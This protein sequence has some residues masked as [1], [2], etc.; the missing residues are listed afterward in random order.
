[1]TDRYIRAVAMDW[2]RIAPDSF[3]RN[4]PA[5]KDL[6]YL[7]FHRN[8]TFFAGENGSGKS[9]LLEAIALAYG[10]NA[11]GGTL[12]YR[13]STYNE[14]GV[15]A[16]AVRLIRGVTGKPGAG[17]FF[18]AESFFNVATAIMEKYNDDGRLPDYHQVSHGESFLDFMSGFDRQGIYL[19]D[20][21]E[22]ALSPQRQLS[23]LIHMIRMAE[24][25]SQFIVATHSPIL[26]GIPDAEI[27]DF[28]EDGIRPCDYEDTESYRVTRL[29]L[30]N[31]E[32]MLHRLLDDSD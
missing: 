8:I 28:R 24:T 20:E 16:D 7:E 27:L 5:M 18:R 12:N 26:L 2:N 4:I 10:F 13:F 32:L 3:L 31:R 22:A 29:F 23:L 17:Y 30:E 14:Q 6:E 1:M 19:M 9:T 21:P 25:G 11:E 15:P